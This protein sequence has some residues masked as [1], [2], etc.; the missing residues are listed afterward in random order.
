MNQEIN[1]FK[2][3]RD[4]QLYC[5]DFATGVISAKGG[6]WGNTIYLDIGSTNHD[7]YVR[8]WCNGKLRMK[9]RL[10]YFLYHGEL[11]C[12]GE[13]IDHYNSIRDCNEIS[14][15]R[16]LTKS[17]NNT[18]CVSRKIGRRTPAQIHEV[19]RLLQDT[20]LSD[21][22]IA[23]TLGYVTRA[24]VRDIKTRRSRKA[25]GSLYIWLHRGY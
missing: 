23:N 16:V 1:D 15:L 11:P 5:V 22:V 17:L 24:T 12:K 25:I 4:E 3:F 21:E 8:L 7:G 14:N 9:H 19:C 10:L 6:R 20:S 18:A 13:E 2:Y